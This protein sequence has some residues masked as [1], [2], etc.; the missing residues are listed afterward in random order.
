MW[1]FRIALAYA[2]IFHGL[3]LLL[4]LQ[5]IPAFGELADIIRSIVVDALSFIALTAYTIGVF[6][7]VF[8]LFGR[9]QIF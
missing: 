1:Q 8:Y 4:I 6:S 5:V 3:S 7:V 9:E 2:I